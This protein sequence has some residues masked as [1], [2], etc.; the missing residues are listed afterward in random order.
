MS[1]R[2]SGGKKVSTV[3][4]LNFVNCS[5]YT[6]GGIAVIFPSIKELLFLC[7]F[8]IFSTFIPAKTLIKFF[9]LFSKMLGLFLNNPIIC[10]FPAVAVCRGF[11]RK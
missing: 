6:Q 4:K 9:T 11:P 3:M 2:T 10:N 7:L 8:F 1:A 5:Q